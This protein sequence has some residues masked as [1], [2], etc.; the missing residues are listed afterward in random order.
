M[1]TFHVQL[2]FQATTAICSIHRSAANTTLKNTSTIYLLP[3]KLVLFAS[4]KALQ[5]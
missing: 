5:K 2:L 4:M 3:K 1:R